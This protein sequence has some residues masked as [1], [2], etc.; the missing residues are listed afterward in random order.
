MECDRRC[1]DSP[2]QWAPER[3]PESGI[4][5]RDNGAFQDEVQMKDQAVWWKTW[6]SP[7]GGFSWQGSFLM[8]RGIIHI[9]VSQWKQPTVKLKSL[10]LVWPQRYLESGKIEGNLGS[11]C[12]AR[13]KDWQD[14]SVLSPRRDF[15]LGLLSFGDWL[16]VNK[17]LQAL[18]W[19]W[20]LSRVKKT[21]RSL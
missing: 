16:V 3:V 11:N 10:S 4:L 7:Q 12:L 14:T 6:E 20:L 15:L 21:I 19:V 18:E 8:G 5:L 17:L 9:I 1:R 2:A 13:E